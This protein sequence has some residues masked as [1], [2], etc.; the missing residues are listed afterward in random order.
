MFCE[1]FYF[2]FLKIHCL[3]NSKLLKHYFI[4]LIL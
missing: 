4:R 3:H 2:Y 1:T